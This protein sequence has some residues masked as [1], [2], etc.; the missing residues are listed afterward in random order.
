MLNLFARPGNQQ[1][2]VLDARV[3]VLLVTCL[4]TNL[5]QIGDNGLDANQRLLDIGQKARVFSINDVHVPY[6]DLKKNKGHHKANPS[7][8]TAEEM[9]CCKHLVPSVV[10]RSFNFILAHS[11]QARQGPE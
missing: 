6:R 2:S 10:K 1:K 8:G 7:C 11:W 4:Q 5:L 3:F 9:W